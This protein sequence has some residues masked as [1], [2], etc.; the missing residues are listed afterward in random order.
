VEATQFRKT[1]VVLAAAHLDSDPTNNRLT[2]LRALC[3]RCHMLHDRPHHLVQR[4]VT[5]RRRLAI[6]DLF[7]GPHPA[8]VAALAS[9]QRDGQF[10]GSPDVALMLIPQHGFEE[11]GHPAAD[12]KCAPLTHI[13]QHIRRCLDPYVQ[14][15]G[16]GPFSKTLAPRLPFVVESDGELAVTDAGCQH[17]I[18]MKIDP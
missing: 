6:G 1:R 16:S 15:T 2:N 11:N 12:G 3:Q 5:Y 18:R 4:R 9:K 17:G 13:L 8:L 14:Q 7:L 10:V